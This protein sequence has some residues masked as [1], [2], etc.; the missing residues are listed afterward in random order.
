MGHLKEEGGGV[1]K[2][3]QAITPKHIYKTKNKQTKKPH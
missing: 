3:R 1:G 2:E